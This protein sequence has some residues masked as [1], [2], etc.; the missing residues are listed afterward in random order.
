VGEVLTLPVDPLSETTRDGQARGHLQYWPEKTGGARRE[1]DVL[2]LTERP[3]SLV[4][5]AVEEIRGI[6]SEARQRAE[7]LEQNRGRAPIEGVSKDDLLKTKKVQDILD[8][9]SGSHTPRVRRTGIPI[10]EREQEG[11]ERPEY[12]CRV[13]DIEEYLLERQGELWTV[14]PSGGEKQRLSDSLFVVNINFFHRKK[15]TKALL[16]DSVSHQNVSDFLNGR[17]ASCEEEHEAAEWR[18]GGWMRCVVPSIFRRFGLEGKD[19]LVR[20][21]TGSGKTAAYAVIILNKIL[22]HHANYL[23]EKKRTSG[24][25]GTHSIFLVKLC[26]AAFS[27]PGKIECVLSQCSVDESCSA[28]SYERACRANGGSVG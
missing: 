9:S 27:E 13:S 3:A 26:N 8:L 5:E 18:N 17:W 28:G 10:L 12:L 4:R 25:K 19:L 2:H 21:K 15:T 7:V 22:K 11:Y 14:N 20:A 6:T 1:K 23:Q 16:V 24:S